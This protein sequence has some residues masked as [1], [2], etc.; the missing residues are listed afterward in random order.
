MNA[1]RQYEADAPK[2][3]LVLVRSQAPVDKPAE[4][5]EATAAPQASG[6]VTADA[7]AIRELW[8]AHGTALMRFALKL[9]LGDRQRAEDIV[10]ETLL[11]AWRHPEVVGGGDQAIRPWLFTVTRHVAIDM[12]RARSRTEE[13]IDDRQV[14]RPDPV[15][16][17]E[18][19]VTALDVRAALSQLTP[20]HRQVIV[21]MYYHGQSVAEISQ[22][23]GIPAGTVKSRTYYGL[24]QLKRVLAAASGE[25][26]ETVSPLPRPVP[27]Q[28]PA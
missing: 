4:P 26:T 13:V 20:E 16:R 22:K 14:E 24:R 25:G 12:W 17:I 8:R 11:R 19:A 18:Q 6:P 9:T 2:P 10:Q 23:L 3:A 21:E 1:A 5:V 7:E 27:R 28:V 15:E